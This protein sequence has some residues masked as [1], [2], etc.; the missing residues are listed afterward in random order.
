MTSSFNTVLGTQRD[1]APDIS[2]WNYAVTEPDLVQSVNN[3][4]DATSKTIQDHFALLVDQENQY[5]KN[6]QLAHK[7]LMDLI[8]RTFPLIVKERDRRA[9]LVLQKDWVDQ[10]NLNDKYNSRF[11]KK[12]PKHPEVIKFNKIEDDHKKE[13][14][15]FHNDEKILQEGTAQVLTAE[16]NAYKAKDHYAAK[17]LEGFGDQ[18]RHER[19]ELTQAHDVSPEFLE[20]ASSTLETQM[21]DGS[22]KTLN[23]VK[24][25]NEYRI[26]YGGIMS[27][28][29]SS[30][31][32]KRDYSPRLVRQLLIKPLFQDYQTAKKAY[33]AKNVEARKV[34]ISEEKSK[35]LIEQVKGQFATGGADNPE[36]LSDE[37][38][39]ENAKK[40]GSVITEY[41]K[42]Y[43][44][45]HEFSWLQSRGELFQYLE[46]A[47]VADQLS[48]AQVEA[49]GNSIIKGHDGG[50]HKLKE[51]WA[52]DYQSLKS[53]LQT[54]KRERYQAKEL[55]DRIAMDESDDRYKEEY[56]SEGFLNLTHD[57]QEEEIKTWQKETLRTLGRPSSYLNGLLTHAEE[58]DL[59][60]EKARLEELI[61]NKNQ[62][63]RIDPS[64]L[65]KFDRDGPVYPLVEELVDK[66]SMNQEEI[67]NA[68]EFVRGETNRYTTEEVAKTDTGSPFW[69]SVRQQADAAFRRYYSDFINK[70]GTT[71]E[72]AYTYAMKEVKKD[73]ENKLY[74]QYP[75]VNP[76]QE[77][78]LNIAKAQRL[79]GQNPT[80][81]DSTEPW[82]GEEVHLR[83]ALS[84]LGYGKIPKGMVDPTVYYAPLLT[85]FGKEKS[86]SDVMEN[87]LIAT[88]LIKDGRVN[89]EKLINLDERIL[90]NHKS[91]PGRTYKAFFQNPDGKE[92]LLEYTDVGNLDELYTSLRFNSQISNSYTTPALDWIQQV[93]IDPIL[94]DQ[95]TDIVG[96]VPFY[97]QLDNLLPGVAEKLVK[98]TL[99]SESAESPKV[100]GSS[101]YSEETGTGWKRS[102][103]GNWEFYRN[104]EISRDDSPFSRDW[105]W[106]K[107]KK[108]W[109]P[110]TYID[111]LKEPA[112][113]AGKYLEQVPGLLSNAFADIPKKLVQEPLESIGSR[114]T[115]SGV[116]ENGRELTVHELEQKNENSKE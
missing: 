76:D 13:E 50:F 33:I 9:A 57:E 16:T 97:S 54:K 19:V 52:K 63:L 40:M 60:W 112:S 107:Y 80:L 5:A 30:V 32:S 95:Y 84:Y 29:V 55:D 74:D 78:S 53:K 27:L 7:E 108:A 51:Y 45:F 21:P 61:D 47:Y 114:T 68:N 92:T 3:E 28:W 96:D 25:L 86:V 36:S 2:K 17:F 79:V 39:K 22:W 59:D 66:K 23:Q 104:F 111:P 88:G 58:A 81:I 90:L 113:K 116:F 14:E 35:A 20:Y 38:V 42:N 73:M 43:H 109:T 37:Q 98:D 102:E 44:G 83:A 26:A 94:A 11:R 99:L 41:I 103:K 56:M 85:G 18:D 12:N 10:D 69:I 115:G 64:E 71:K 106:D 101:I 100:P 1:A 82:E 46:D 87:R 24:N 6:K 65:R 75:V 48:D 91:T 31:I 62:G 93:N 89:P 49:I 110:S 34:T 8:P 70:P 77:L 72:G 105:I 67:A 15:I 4:I